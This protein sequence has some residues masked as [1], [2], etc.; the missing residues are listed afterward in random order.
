M[1][2][3]KEYIRQAA[4]KCGW[5]RYYSIYRPVSPGTYPKNGMMDFINYDT[6]VEID[7]KMIWAELYYERRLEQKELEDYELVEG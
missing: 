1:M 5:F 3:V 7:G 4:K 2:G 6:R